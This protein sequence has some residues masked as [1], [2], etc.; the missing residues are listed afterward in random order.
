MVAEK[1]EVPIHVFTND[2]SIARSLMR[3]KNPSYDDAIELTGSVV[4]VYKQRFNYLIT[5]PN[6]LGPHI[7]FLALIDQ[8]ED[9]GTVAEAIVEWLEGGKA[10]IFSFNR[11]V[12]DLNEKFGARMAIEDILTKLIDQQ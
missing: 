5:T 10:T 1:I 7:D 2:M 4:L 9:K 12:L 6:G 3:K 8:G 11:I